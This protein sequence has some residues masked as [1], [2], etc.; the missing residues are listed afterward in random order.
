VRLIERRSPNRWQV[1]IQAA[2]VYAG[3]AVSVK[4]GIGMRDRPRVAT[5]TARAPTTRTVSWWMHIE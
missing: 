3:A 1:A 2:A 4:D 5:A